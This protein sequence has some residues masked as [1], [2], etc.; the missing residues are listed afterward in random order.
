MITT[1]KIKEG[2]RSIAELDMQNAS[3]LGRLNPRLQLV[4]LSRSEEHSG[5]TLRNIV[6]ADVTLRL[7]YGHELVGEGRITGHAL[8]EGHSF[9]LEVVTSHRLLQYVT[10]GLTPGAPNLE[11]RASLRGLVRVH[12][13]HPQS[14]A[15]EPCLAREIYLRPGALDPLQIARA[16]W[17]ESVLSPTRN[18]QYRYL[19][20]A[21]PRDDQA[22]TAEWGKTVALLDEAERAY[23]LGD[24]AAV[25]F[26]LRGAFDALP[27]AK[28]RILDGITDA[29]KHARLDSLLH[30]A[31][32]FLHAGRHVSVSGEQQGE[33]PVD[34]LDAGFALDLMRVL[35]SHLSL[36]LSAEGAR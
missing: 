28:Q 34:H 29:K 23:A 9:Q 2:S 4:F 35:F 24:D 5:I 6:L 32:Q 20:I 1:L 15:Q 36:M 22:L 10:G 7:E 27:G 17:Y 19:E 26:Q 3:G 12:P 30:Q 33:F 21:L 18:E 11:L 8:G 14:D 31:G 16:A 25:F 13:E